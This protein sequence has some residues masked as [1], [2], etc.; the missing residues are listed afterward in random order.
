MVKY[1]DDCRHCYCPCVI[2][3][4]LP[5]KPETTVRFYDCHEVDLDNDQY[6]IPITEEQFARYVQ[7]RICKENSL[8]NQVI[9]GFN[10]ERKAFML[11]T[12][13]ERRDTGHRYLIKWFN[14][15]EN[16]QK[17]EHL[18]GAFIRRNEHRKDGYVLAIDDNDQIYKPAKTI[19]VSDDKK[20]LTIRY[21]NLV[22]K[23]YSKYELFFDY[24]NCK[25]CVFRSVEVPAITTFTITKYYLHKIGDLLRT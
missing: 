12:I 23:S 4:H 17:E 1:P 7:C 2:R 6:V 13:K 19:K 11:G 16:E 10:D 21:K 22:E 8:I 15:D 20:Q 5:N 9:V 18:F 14:G 24:F 25:S 3:H